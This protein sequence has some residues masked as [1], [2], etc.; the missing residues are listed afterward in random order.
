MKPFRVLLVDDE[1]ELVSTIV[2]RL[3]FRG[4]TAEAVTNG[5]DALEK[6]SANPFDVIVAD[7]KMPGLSGTE[8]I[9]VL[10]HRYPDARVILI[11]GHGSTPEE[12][13]TDIEG[14]SEILMKPFSLDQ[15]IAT[16]YR[17]MK[18]EDGG[19]DES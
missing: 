15:L 9:G 7:L 4:I 16:I 10:H 17:V 12:N 5:H 19:S 1:V 18:D 6:M 13:H 14:V 2:E 3:E 8:V 11:T